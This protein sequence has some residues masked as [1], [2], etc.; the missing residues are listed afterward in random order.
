MGFRS[1]EFGRNSP[2]CPGVSDNQPTNA[3]CVL[4]ERKPQNL[5]SLNRLR[6]EAVSDMSLVATFRNIRQ[7]CEHFTL[8]ECIVTMLVMMMINDDDDDARV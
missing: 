1:V 3:C 7:Q 5:F 2:V 6:L 8:F 4:I